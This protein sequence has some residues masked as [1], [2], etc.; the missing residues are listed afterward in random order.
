VPNTKVKLLKY[1][2]Q[3]HLSLAAGKESLLDPTPQFSPNDDRPLVVC[4][5]VRGL[6]NLSEDELW[7]HLGLT[8]KTIPFFNAHLDPEGNYHPWDK[9]HGKSWFEKEENSVLLTLHLFQLVGIAKMLENTFS[10]KP[11]LLMDTVG[12]GKTIQVTAFIA[13]LAYYHHYYEA[14]K[15]EHSVGYLAISLLP[16]LSLPPSF[17][18]THIYL[19]VYLLLGSDAFFCLTA[20]KKWRPDSS[21]IPDWP[22]LLVVPVNLHNQTITEL[23]RFIKPSC[24]NIL[25]YT[26]SW[27]GRDMY[28]EKISKLSNQR[29]G[30]LLMVATPLVSI[31]QIHQE[32]NSI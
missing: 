32:E 5:L 9:K 25:P 31:S 21:N 18:I 13:I 26:Q 29:K 11:V 27:S 24:F 4:V 10:G 22:I 28:W 1:K 30:R 6:N 23:Q 14:H 12:L 3:E 2:L 7:K 16:F 15:L 19:S 8:D 20:S 17:K